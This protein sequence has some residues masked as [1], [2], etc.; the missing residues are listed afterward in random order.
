MTRA[1]TEQA[2]LW[3]LQPEIVAEMGGRLSEFWKGFAECVTTKTRDTRA[4]GFAYLSGLL[5]IDRCRNMAE[6]GRQTG[7]SEQ[8]MQHF[9][10]NSLW[11]GHVMIGQV[12][13]AIGKRPEL[14]QGILVIDESADEK[15]GLH[16]A[17]SGRQHNGRLG[18]IDVAQV[19]VFATLVRDHHWSWV[20]GEL[21]L[22]EV[23]F[24]EAYAKKRTA[25]GIPTERRF[26]TKVELAW[27]LIER[28]YAGPIAFEAVAFDSL[29]GR[30][31]WLRDQCR[32]K[33]I[34]YYADI[35]RSGWVYLEA[36]TAEFPVGKRGK[37]LKQ[38]PIWTGANALKAES[39]LDDP[40]TEWHTLTLRPTERG[41]LVADFAGRQVWTTRSD[42]TVVAET[43][44]L[45]RDS[46]RVTYSLTNA[47]TE[48]PLQ[49][50]AERKSQRS[51]VE[52]SIQDAKSD[53]GW[54]DFRAIKYRAWEHQLAFT[55]LA[56]WFV[57]E[58]RLDWE[59]DMP[60]DPSLFEHYQTDVLPALSMANVREMLR[61]AM[62][63]PQ[64][65]TDD[66]IALVLKHL[67]NRTRSRRSRLKRRM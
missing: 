43:L 38:K 4:Y 50:L 26:E 63:L 1:I 20:D 3:G 59:R 23:W 49:L 8:N 24:S 66:A 51:F 27:R 54:D 9:M 58:T 6:I 28:I 15:A 42:G 7:V 60:A 67:D 25:S 5:R 55:I 37:P 22:P 34:E 47:P 17:G 64:L 11:D 2:E 36:P 52:R 16:S 53:L 44:L 31:V 48:S 10:S 21:F 56:S 33:N 29:Y 35:P 12:Q 57:A 18:K 19:G 65:S 45:R 41:Y 62:P 61:A 32:A 13:Q 30:S 14:Q 40:Q 46:D 39:L